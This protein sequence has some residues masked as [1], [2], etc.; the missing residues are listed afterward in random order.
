MPNP[1]EV[2]RDLRGFV[3]VTRLLGLAVS[4]ILPATAA[5][6]QLDT[7]TVPANGP[8]RAHVNVK[9][10][11]RFAITV[12]SRQGVSVQLVDRV[13]GP[14][15]VEGRAGHADGR[16]D[17]Y[18]DRGTYRILTNGDPAAEGKAQLNVRRYQ[19]LNG[20]AP[21]QL[22]ELKPI[23]APL[24]DVEK[25]SYWLDI[26]KRRTVAL[27]AA[28][29]NLTDLRLWKDGTWL[30]DAEPATDTIEP[31]TG[32]PMRVRRLAANLEPGL[33][34][35][36]AYGG[37][38]LAWAEDDG[39]HPFHLRFGVETNP[40]AL[41]RRHVIGPFGYDRF[42]V[43]GA[44]YF[45]VELEEARSLE[46]DIRRYNASNPFVSSSLSRVSISKKSVPP[47]A[48]TNVSSGPHL[49]TVKG[50]PGRPYVLQHFQ[51]RHY[52]VL[53]K[54]PHYVATV[55][56]GHAE[57][58]IDATG[59]VVSGTS[60]H[61]AVSWQTVKVSGDRS[62]G[63][64]FNLMAMATVFV[65]V[66]EDGPY[67]ILA[68]GSGRARIRVE[69]FLVSKPRGYKT[70][71]FQ[72]SGHKWELQKGL[73][74]VTIDPEKQGIVD[75]A[76]SRTGAIHNT[77]QSLLGGTKQAS[78]RPALR[79][80][81]HDVPRYGHRLYVSQQPGVSVGIIARKLPVD[82]REPLAVAQRPDETF[83]IH[84][85]IEEEGLLYAQAE[86]GTRLDVSVDGGPW[87]KSARPSIGAHRVRVRH[88]GKNIAQYALGLRTKRTD[89]DTPLPKLPDARLANLP[90]FEVLADRKPTYLDLDR[91]SAA[92]Y[93]VQAS[94]AGLYRL[95]STGLLATS[96][97]LR[98]RVVTRLV[99][100]KQNGVG[101]NF[102]VQQ[103]L[104]VGDYQLTAR[105][106]GRTKGHLGLRLSR[107]NERN[108]GKL[109]D[110]IPARATLPAGETLMY[111]FRI[112]KAG[113]YRLRAIGRDRTFRA[114]LED[115]EGWPIERPNVTADFDRYFEPGRYRLVVLPQTVDARVVTVLERQR[116]A[117]ERVGHG[118]HA[119]AI[120][121]TV[122]HVWTG[123]KKSARD[124]WRFEVPADIDA[125]IELG[126]KMHGDVFR[127][128]GKKKTKVA[129]V[130]P[131]RGWRG[132]LAKGRYR[133][134]ARHLHTTKGA[135]Y[136]VA[137]RAVQLVV[138][139]TWKVR[140]PN[141]VELAV[142]TEE[143]VEISSFGSSDVEARLVDNDGRVVAKSDDR[144][145]DWNFLLATRLEPGRYRLYVDPVAKRR[146]RTEVTVATRVEQLAK[147][148]SV[149]TGKKI[150]VGAK[151]RVYPLDVPS[152]ARF[153]V[154]WARSPETIGLALSAKTD[155]GWRTIAEN[156]GR[157]A[158]VEVPLERGGQHRLEVWSVD[159][160]GSSIVLDVHAVK[161]TTVT[162]AELGKGLV[163]RRSTSRLPVAI[164]QVRLDRPGTF[165]FDD[166]VRVS[167]TASTPLVPLARGLAHAS[168]NT[169]WVARP[170][171]G[172]RL[173]GR[174]VTRSGGRLPLTIGKA[175]VSVDLEGKGYALAMV[176]A[177]KAVPGVA[178][179]E[180]SEVL[181]P[182]H[183]D[184]TD[185]GRAVAVRFEDGALRAHLF[186]ASPAPDAFDAALSVRRFARAKPEALTGGI[187][188]GAVPAGGA[189][190]LSLPA[191]RH[192]FRIAM[193]EGGV[194]AVG[195]DR[196]GRVVVSAGAVER[197]DADARRVVVLNPTKTA[198]AYVVEASPSI[199]TRTVPYEAVE[200][201]EGR[202]ELVVPP[203]ARTRVLRIRGAEH[204][205]FV[206]ADGQVA[207]G[208][209]MPV[210]A[211]GGV[212]RVRHGAG[213]VMAWVDEGRPFEGLF[214]DRAGASVRATPGVVKLSGAEATLG[215]QTDTPALFVARI[216]APVVAR[217]QVDG[218]TPQVDVAPRG[219]S[220]A[221][222]LASGAGKLRV[223]AVADAV[224]PRA[225]TLAKQEVTALS[226][227]IGPE[228]I[229]GPGQAQAF[230][231][232]VP[233]KRSI[234]IGIRATSA[235]VTA[236]LRKTDGTVVGRGV[237]Q[238]HELD[239]G[240]YVLVVT[241]PPAGQVARVRPA[242]VGLEKPSTG[243]PPD[244]LRGYLSKAG[245]SEA[246]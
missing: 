157:P 24:G 91:N 222:F 33:Y 204:A 236:E 55:H 89:P 102:L 25:R 192:R 154:A 210:G 13:S 203:S 209:A 88:T 11:G 84:A 225:I 92:S 119:I 200:I 5:A 26:T 76:M 59:I 244:V 20:P 150:V 238:M 167:S 178:V 83:S 158:H 46:L 30:V 144:P 228:V 177:T 77:I 185:G 132:P 188:R 155:R 131:L 123:G 240:T 182:A 242:V 37:P 218:T 241:S 23:D 239:A 99:E 7:R 235:D 162:E 163:T 96:G 116:P 50:R 17:T 175:P 213:P 134:E 56:A 189:V 117:V 128:D 170:K 164:L 66:A 166:D 148:I 108:G 105:T 16:I 122:H 130:P 245:Y 197:F 226:E 4:L 180:P 195:S 198:L 58:S 208:T 121:E 71:A 143:L 126:G 74:V 173:F 146:A 101:R 231:F 142:G 168:T 230:T 199:A 112:E 187:R 65:E 211:R 104:G 38:P 165:R 81:K 93:L 78:L 196:V 224:L 19:E 9:A 149:E 80:E 98:T 49:V 220:L 120:D 40:E 219:A 207:I 15:T 216:G 139:R 44:N 125:K 82:L 181:S 61:S 111:R 232:A 21:A 14:G 233:D 138:G 115:N 22:V 229:V 212:V 8:G 36:T 48:E 110:R 118:P 29:R 97:T 34:L 141:V 103:Y 95:E 31:K 39:S 159:Q 75:V 47:V 201:G 223:R 10:F 215:L 136:N 191:G 217:W 160:R 124:V 243:P 60:P 190:E 53:K 206:G 169:L 32:R 35:V 140:A 127:L 237:A 227:G 106:L 183:F 18:L 27:E 145:D 2:W 114:R 151:K 129:Y 70:P 221:T 133:L 179:L 45:R 86:D 12:K 171:K 94:K 156:V 79:F 41:R 100:Q 67:R 193:D 135:P 73:Y 147:P 28:G 72:S 152:D 234:G 137:V 113:R 246:P 69:P 205:T 214:A 87:T 62:W 109:I 184:V 43:H 63:R 42:I 90:K 85:T 107:T 1:R 194:A 3:R 174:R 64:R 68:T 153:L 186:A 172:G 161:P 54:G 176:A 6:Q 51:T 57:D 202:L 52:V